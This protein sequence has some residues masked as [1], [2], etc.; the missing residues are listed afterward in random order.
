MPVAFHSPMRANSAS[1]SS[2]IRSVS[3]IG[4]GLNP[5]IAVRARHVGQQRVGKLAVLVQRHLVPPV[6]Q[7]GELDAFPE[8]SLPDC[9]VKK[10]L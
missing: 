9:V 4:N 7:A 1:P 10:L 2:M 8:P 6:H 5:R 3:T